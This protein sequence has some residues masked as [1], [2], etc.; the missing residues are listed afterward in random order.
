M[1]HG[2]Q[3][4]FDTDKTNAQG[5]KKRYNSQVTISRPSNF[6]GNSNHIKEILL[7][8]TDKDGNKIT[9]LKTYS[10]NIGEVDYF[11]RSY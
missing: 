7:T 5:Y 2:T 8:V 4:I 10:A 11:K 9:V 1:Q 6:N 3:N